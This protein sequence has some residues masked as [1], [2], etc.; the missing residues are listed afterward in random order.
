MNEIRNA[1][2]AITKI[3]SDLEK[4][5]GGVVESIRIH[6]VDITSLDDSAKKIKRIVNIVLI[7][8]STWGT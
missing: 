4:E 1:Q 6:N 7:T 2:E 3:L 8:K 5:S